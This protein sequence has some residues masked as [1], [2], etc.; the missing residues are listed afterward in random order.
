LGKEGRERKGEGEGREREG[1][2]G[3]GPNQVSRE[4]DATGCKI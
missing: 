3:E 1:G 4:I 2:E